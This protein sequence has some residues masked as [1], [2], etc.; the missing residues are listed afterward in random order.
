MHL[1]GFPEFDT[2]MKA[3]VIEIPVQVNGKMRGNI[4]LNDVNM[5]EDEVVKLAMASE[6]IAKFVDG[7][8]IR[9]VIY[10]RERILNLVVG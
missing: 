1:Q 7:K 5:E 6:E 10:V 2:D 3:A 9:K 8:E 4:E